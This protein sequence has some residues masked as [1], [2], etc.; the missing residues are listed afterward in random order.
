MIKEVHMRRIMILIVAFV[1]AT[2]GCGS[3]NTVSDQA[4]NAADA[5]T[6]TVAAEPVTTTTTAPSAAWPAEGEPW[7][8][9]YIS[10]S[11]GWGVADLL[12]EQAAEALGV[13]VRV[14]DH[15]SGGLSAVTALA[16]IRG[17]AY[18]NISDWV[19]ESEIIV[20]YGNP[21]DSGAD[22]EIG[23]C[24][25]TSIMEREPPAHQTAAD[26][27][28]Y[29]K[30]LDEL[31]AEIWK[32]REGTPTV[33]RAIDLYNPVISAWREAGIDPECTEHWE[34]WSSVI[35]GAAEAN[36]AVMVSTYDLFNGPSHDE[37]PR[38]K[39]YIGSDGEHTT[40]QGAAAIAAAIAAKGFE[41]T[42]PPGD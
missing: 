9:L 29:E 15:A 37:D 3:D 23:T 12:A 42:A 6:T 33:L 8:L 4:Q 36:G 19:R 28:P 13:E 25:S 30:V 5:T 27:Q 17:D 41:P 1:L 11:G 24:V 31:Y 22:L 2:A 7:D 26:Y 20:V 18:P 39:G 34:L 10:D 38:E 14:Y 21:E 40:T 35:R 32:L 16:R